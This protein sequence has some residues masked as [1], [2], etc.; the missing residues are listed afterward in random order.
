M[1][2]LNK[3]IVGKLAGN[4]LSRFKFQ[5]FRGGGHTPKSLS[6]ER[7]VASGHLCFI[8]FIETYSSI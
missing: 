8:I 3:I 7:F 6:V 4:A 1:V 5:N 2:T